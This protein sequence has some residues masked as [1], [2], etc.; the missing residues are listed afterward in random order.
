MKPGSARITIIVFSLLLFLVP[1]IYDLLSE[2][3]SGGIG[4]HQWALIFIAVANLGFLLFPRIVSAVASVEL[5]V[6][7]TAV[8]AEVVITSVYLFTPLL[9]PPRSYV[10]HADPDSAGSAQLDLPG[11]RISSV[12]R[13]QARITGNTVEWIGTRKGNNWGY[14]DKDDFVMEKNPGTLRIAVFG[15]SFTDAQYLD[16]SWPDKVEEIAGESDRN[17]ELYNFAFN[18]AG[19]G[20]WWYSLRFDIHSRDW[21]FDAFVFAVAS[22]DLYRGLEYDGKR[23]VWEDLG[24]IFDGR[25]YLAKMP[26]EEKPG[27]AWSVPSFYVDTKVFEAAISGNW[28]PPPET[29]NKP[30]APY[31]FNTLL[32]AYLYEPRELYASALDRGWLDVVEDVKRMVA[33][34][35]VLVI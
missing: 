18:G 19:L 34:K 16:I 1:I 26:I 9:D 31:L 22:S 25:G 33:N 6:V 14:S 24:R 11:M 3:T 15:D 30:L 13:R 5:I 29:A 23:Y 21:D 12:P 27:A 20:N 4:K 10:V 32:A 7:V 35:P 2:S 17:L 8:M 28:S